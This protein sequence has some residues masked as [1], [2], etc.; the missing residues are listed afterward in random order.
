MI[1]IIFSFF[2]LGSYFLFRSK[3][4]FLTSS[5]KIFLPRLFKCG[6]Y[7]PNSNSVKEHNLFESFVEVVLV[8][9]LFW[10]TCL[11][12]KGELN[13]LKDMSCV[14]ETCHKCE[15]TDGQGK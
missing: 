13:K 5:L 10:K 11:T 12:N 9:T 7:P 8:L 2:F 1:R 6:N 3:A 4:C 14:K 15:G